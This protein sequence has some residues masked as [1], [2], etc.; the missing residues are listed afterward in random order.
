MQSSGND[1]TPQSGGEDFKS[2]QIQHWLPNLHWFYM[3][4]IATLGHLGK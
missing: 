3:A 2:S 4:L 1:L